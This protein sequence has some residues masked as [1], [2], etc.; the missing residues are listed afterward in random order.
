MTFYYIRHGEPIYRPD[1]LTKKGELQANALSEK[2]G[3]IKIDRIFTST[4]IRAIQTAKPTADILKLEIEQ[5]D[6]AK[7]HH[8][9]QELTVIDEDEKRHWMF[10]SDSARKLFVSEEVLKL[11][12]EWYEYPAFKD[13]KAKEGIKRITNASDEFFKKL[14]YEHISGTG[15]YK[16]LDDNNDRVAFFAH[17]GFGLAFL[18]CLL[19]IP[20]PRFSMHFDMG[21]SGV[22]VIEFKNEDGIASPKI[23]T[24]SNDSH[25]YREGLPTKYQNQI[26]F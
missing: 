6:F 12:G 1:S 7:E 26:Y 17:Q 21:H 9:W 2:L 16:V 5:L 11:G 19:D 13:T 4:S 18:S 10:Q 23:L 20:Y 14:G 3:Q 24:L 15:A 22:T 8:A 25:L